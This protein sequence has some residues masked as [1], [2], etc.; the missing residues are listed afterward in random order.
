MADLDRHRVRG[1]QRIGGAWAHITTDLIF[2]DGKPY[3]VAE[4]TFQNGEQ[5]PLRIV[6]LDPQR[7]SKMQSGDADYLYDGQIAEP[8]LTH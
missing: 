5:V 1:L 4:W 3:S 8:P 7:L 6:A 2:Q